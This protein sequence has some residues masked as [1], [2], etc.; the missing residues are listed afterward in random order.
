MDISEDADYQQYQ[1]YIKVQLLAEAKPLICHETR[2]Q[3]ANMIRTPSNY[4]Y[5]PHKP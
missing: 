3:L 5:K 2:D 4:R 1:V